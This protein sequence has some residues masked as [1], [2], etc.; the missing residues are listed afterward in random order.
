MSRETLIQLILTFAAVKLAKV[1]REQTGK[2]SNNC[3]VNWHFANLAICTLL[4]IATIILTVLAQQYEEKSEDWY[5][6]LYYLEIMECAFH[7]VQ[8]YVDLFL[9]FLL[10]RFTR[11]QKT[12]KAGLT[13]AQALLLDITTKNDKKINTD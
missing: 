13:E 10:Y 6:Y 12:V 4:L 3:L 8:F 1:I 5:R 11:T 9:L 2:K 7:A